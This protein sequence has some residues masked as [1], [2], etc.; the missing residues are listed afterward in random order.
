MKTRPR[1]LPLVVFSLAAQTAAGMLIWLAALSLFDNSL[2]I[3]QA[4]VSGWALALTLGGLLASLLHLGNPQRALLAMRKLNKSWISR[5]VAI[6]AVFCL[7]TAGFFLS[8]L[9]YSPSATFGAVLPRFLLWLSAVLGAFL[10]YAMA[11]VYRL[12]TAPNWGGASTGP[13]F[14]LT[15]LL[16]GG[17]LLGWPLISLRLLPVGPGGTLLR[18][19][20]LICL[21]LQ[22]GIRLLDGSGQS[23]KV[24]PV[25][26]DRRALPILQIGLLLAAFAALVFWQS[27]ISAALIL[28]AEL[29]GRLEFYSTRRRLGV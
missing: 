29:I 27:L 17:S 4:V 3:H 5:E 21:G 1:E 18:L 16:L 9:L 14:F 13:R 19:G 2:G 15:A 22:I 10:I 28:S 8:T 23:R 24:P 7:T 25:F 20:L 6:A 11:Q 26:T 12:R